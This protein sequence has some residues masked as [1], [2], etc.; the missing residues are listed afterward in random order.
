MCRK[1]HEGLYCISFFFAV[2]GYLCPIQLR[3]VFCVFFCKKLLFFL[4]TCSA[5]LSFKLGFFHFE[6]Y[7]C[8]PEIY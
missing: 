8:C 5:N 2:L 6:V 1:G 7:G 3:S 4:L